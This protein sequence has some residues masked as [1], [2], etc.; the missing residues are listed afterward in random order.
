MGCGAVESIGDFFQDSIIDPIKDVFQTIDDKLLEPIYNPIKEVIDPLLPEWIKEAPGTIKDRLLD[1]QHLLRHP[2]ELWRVPR[3]IFIDAADPLLSEKV[4]DFLHKPGRTLAA[5]WV[6]ENKATQAIIEGIMGVVGVILAPMTGGASLWIS[7]L[8][9]TGFGMLSGSEYVPEGASFGESILPV[10]FGALEGYGMSQLGASITNG[11]VAVSNGGNFIEGFTQGY[12][13]YAENIAPGQGLQT[14]LTP[15]M[16]QALTEVDTVFAP[17]TNAGGSISAAGNLTVN[18]VPLSAFAPTEAMK[19]ALPQYIDGVMSGA[20]KATGASATGQGTGMLAQLYDDVGNIAR[21]VSNVSGT[22]GR[23]SGEQQPE[24]MSYV[25]MVGMVGPTVQ[26]AQNAG[27]NIY[28]FFSPQQAQQIANSS[29]IANTLDRFQQPQQNLTVGG[30]MPYLTGAINP[31][32]TGSIFSNIPSSSVPGTQGWLSG[33]ASDPTGQLGGYNGYNPNFDITQYQIPSQNL[34]V[35]GGQPFD[36]NALLG[37]INKTANTV[38]QIYGGYQ[39]V[40]GQGGAI[41]QTQQTQQGVYVPSVYGTQSYGGYG[42]PSYGA[43]APSFNPSAIYGAPTYGN[44]DPTNTF[45]PTIN[46]Q[47][48]QY[49]IDY[50]NVIQSLFPSSSGGGTSNMSGITDLLSQLFG[51]GGGQPPAGILNDN[52]D[53]ASGFTGAGLDNFD[54]FLNLLKGVN[55]NQ[56][57]GGITGLIQSITGNPTINKLLEL[58][59]TG[60][61]SRQQSKQNEQQRNWLNELYAPQKEA[62]ATN[63]GLLQNVYKP[64][65]ESQFNLYKDIFEP[66]S[67]QLGGQLQADLTSPFSLG[68][69]LEGDIWRRA[70]ERVGGEYEKVSRSASERLAGSGMLGQGPA[71]QYFQNLGQQKLK[72]LEDVAV[73]QAIWE[74]GQKNQEKTDRYNRMTSFLNTSKINAPNV[75]GYGTPQYPNQQVDWSKLIDIFSNN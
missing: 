65:Q 60:V 53:L 58:V 54:N 68:S 71:E 24:W 12:K 19:A 75:S 10:G 21:T 22:Y 73:E 61:A 59:A 69:D 6:P 72:S 66:S 20:I 31:Y 5:A 57:A 3:D 2:A 44:Y 63:L 70:K 43:Y 26:A 30:Q 29:A 41:P 46:N 16:T 14:T 64:Y 74:Y 35:S 39:A 11:V 17:I 25:N 9:A 55:P 1:P 4:K 36:W 34:T 8:A 15:Q 56:N 7:R 13:S 33:Y 45:S 38:G 28:E 47:N 42:V 23:V 37:N 62:Q 48:I 27:K 40:T 52:Q 32:Y 51:D 49:P 67:R 18:G 50:E